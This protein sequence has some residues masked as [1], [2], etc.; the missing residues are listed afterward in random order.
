MLRRFALAALNAFTIPATVL[1]N[2]GRIT[3][4]N[5]AAVKDAPVALDEVIGRDFVEVFFAGRI[6]NDDGLFL[7]PVFQTL[8]AGKELCNRPMVIKNDRHRQPGKYSVTTWI[9]REERQVMM[10]LGLYYPYPTAKNLFFEKMSEIRSISRLLDISDPYT[11]GHM[12]R[13]TLYALAI[14][15]RLSLSRPQL[16]TLSASAITHD[17]GK[18][19]VSRPILNKPGRLTPEELGAMRSHAVR[20][21]EILRQHGMPGEVVRVVRHHHERFDGSGYPDGLAGADIPLLSRILAVADAFEAMTAD[22]VYRPAMSNKVA[23]NELVNHAGTQFDPEI[24]EVF[25]AFAQANDIENCKGYR[26]C[27]QE[28]PCGHC[29]HVLGNAAG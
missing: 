19:L 17:C 28:K 16:D 21:T 1:D 8:V 10:V 4:L 5:E 3:A 11:T 23:V 14:A 6:Y 24:V 18:V 22:R 2:A 29:L 15:E 13:V 9:M 20:G 27:I 25:L 12:E 7:S 26:A